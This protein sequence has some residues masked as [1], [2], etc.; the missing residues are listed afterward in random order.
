MIEFMILEAASE[1]GVRASGRDGRHRV[2]QREPIALLAIALVFFLLPLAGCAGGS[3]QVLPPPPQNQPTTIGF[4]SARAVDGS[5]AANTNST[6]NVWVVKT[7]GSGATPLTKLTAIGADTFSDAWSPDGSKIVMN[8]RRALDGSD[9][10]NTNGTNNIWVMKSDGT[11]AVPLTKLTAGGADSFDPVWSPDGSKIAFDSQ[12]ALDGSD[13]A[14]AGNIW[15]V[16]ADGSGAAPLTKL[17]NIFA[18]SSTPVWSPD[19]SK[20]AFTSRRALDGS[21]AANTNNTRNIWVMKS[22][23]TGATPLTKLTA[24]GA[25][26]GDLVWSPDGTKIAFDSRRALDGSDALNT[27]NTTNIWMM[28]SDGTAATPLTRLTA[29]NADSLDPVWSRDG[30]KLAF[31]S[32][33]ALDGSNAANGNNVSNIW[34]MSTDGSGPVPLTKLTVHNADSC[35]P[36][37]KP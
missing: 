22:D 23:G 24:S 17:T 35:C 3:M 1:N 19:G 27:N 20:I 18:S 25:S 15:V 26:S 8:A 16:N 37:W 7:D 36:G 6:Q 30:S 28:N 12:R 29:A 5:A 9:A 14:E 2:A 10:E 33:R 32:Q 13:A 11:G 21:N 4:T 34:V 31:D